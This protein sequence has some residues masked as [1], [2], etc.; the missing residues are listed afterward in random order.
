MGSC[1][2]ESSSPDSATDSRYPAPRGCTRTSRSA[3]SRRLR[4]DAPDPLPRQALTRP[5]GGEPK[6]SRASRVRSATGET[7]ASRRIRLPG[8]IEL[9]GSSEKLPGHGGD[10]GPD[11]EVQVPL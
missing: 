5:P 6:W 10:L 4:H 11:R 3:D 1:Q 8:A 9:P 7:W 2:L